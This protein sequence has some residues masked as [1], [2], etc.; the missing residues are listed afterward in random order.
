MSNC[1][2]NIVSSVVHSSALSLQLSQQPRQKQLERD[3]TA[4]LDSSVS[5]ELDISQQLQ[6]AASAH[7]RAVLQQAPSPR[8]RTLL[9]RL[10]LETLQML[11]AA[12][13]TDEQRSM[14]QWAAAVL[15]GPNWRSF[16]LQTPQ[17]DKSD[18]PATTRARNLSD[19]SN[20]VDFYGFSGPTDRSSKC[21]LQVKQL[22][23]HRVKWQLW[24]SDH[25]IQQVPCSYL[26]PTCQL[27]L[28]PAPVMCSDMRDLVRRGVPV[29]L[30]GFIWFQVSGAHVKFSKAAALRKEGELSY[31]QQKL[32]DLNAGLELEQ[33]E[34]QRDILKDIG[35]TWTNNVVHMDA[36]FRVRLRNVLMCYSVRNPQ[37]GY[38]QS[39]NFIAGLF[40]LF[41]DEES[42]F[43][44]LATLVLRESLPRARRS[45]VVQVEELMPQFF[46]RS[47]FAL[48]RDQEILSQCVCD[49]HLQE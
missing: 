28:K 46:G 25:S 13:D 37:I 40:L 17:D 15:L 27:L 2:E 23:A 39:M 41:L 10:H 7:C 43:W 35:R 6:S 8:L 9:D 33:T 4:A 45:P 22:Q 49:L 16:S 14:Q 11:S 3:R 44:L 24:L 30:R 36:A 26:S 38:C 12:G 21:F 32:H 29:D 34:S 19:P 5:S 47:L 48:V 31:Y 20:S 18:T 42:T 1:D